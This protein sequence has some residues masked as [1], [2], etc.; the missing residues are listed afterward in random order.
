MLSL[1]YLNRFVC[2]FQLQVLRCVHDSFV[3]CLRFVWGVSKINR[4][5]AITAPLPRSPKIELRIVPSL[6]R[7]CRIKWERRRW[8]YSK[9]DLRTLWYW[10]RSHILTHLKHKAEAN[11]QHMRFYC[12]TLIFDWVMIE[13]N[14]ILRIPFSESRLFI[15]IDNYIFDCTNLEM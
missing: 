12:D 5:F 11:R 10:A 9:F 13:T 2:Q 4:T 8:H 3:M 14:Y 6:S 15:D 7:I 1:T